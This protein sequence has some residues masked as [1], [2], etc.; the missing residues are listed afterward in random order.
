MRIGTFDLGQFYPETNLQT[1]A[2]A[3]LLAGGAMV[4]DAYGASAGVSFASGVGALA[5]GWVSRQAITSWM[6]DN[7]LLGSDLDEWTATDNPVDYSELLEALEAHGLVGAR[8]AGALPGPVLTRH[9]IRIP[10][11]TRL[12]KLPDDDIARDMGAPDITITRN[13]GRGLIALDVPNGSRDTV[14][15]STLLESPQWATQRKGMK[16]PACPGV[17]ATGKPFVF[18]LKRA[19]HLFVAGTTGAGKSVLV[20]AILLSLLRSGA[21]FSLMIGDGKGEDFAPYYGDSGRMVQTY[22]ITRTVGNV[23]VTTPAALPLATEVLDIAAQ[24]EWLEAEMDARFSGGDKSTPIVFVVDELADVLGLAKRDKKLMTEERLQ[25]LAQKGRSANIHMILCTQSPNSEIFSQTFRA[26][27]PSAIGL[28]TKTA[29][30]SKVAIQSTGCEKLLGD[31]D[32]FAVIGAET[33]RIHGALVTGADILSTLGR[34]AII[35]QSN[36]E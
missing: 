33:T 30:Q 23:E 19:V 7:C 29:D 12:G 6:R 18:D 28:K 9:L 31:G 3:L 14:E 4:A 22:D 15:F 27:I 11:G 36:K 10:K 20:N 17:D 5:L 16:L 21:G 26:N 24:A 2:S 8:H 13:A 1:A 34:G 35:S 32:A 25:R